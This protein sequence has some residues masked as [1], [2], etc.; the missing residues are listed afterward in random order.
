MDSK[1]NR[2]SRGSITVFLCLVVTLLMAL[3]LSCLESARA[4]AARFMAESYVDVAATSAL[5]DFDSV[6]FERYHVFG[7]HSDVDYSMRINMLRNMDNAIGIDSNLV[8]MGASALEAMGISDEANSVLGNLEMV[9]LTDLDIIE[10]HDYFGMEL[11]DLKI[12]NSVP[13][14]GR[15]GDVF[16]SQAVSYAEKSIP[17]TLIEKVLE[18]AG[19]LSKT[20]VLEN[21]MS[22]KSAAYT[23]LEEVDR[24]ASDL[25]MLIDG[26]EVEK[27]K[28]LFGDSAKAQKNCFKS[29]AFHGAD[30]GALNITSE[31]VYNNLKSYIVDLKAP[32]DVLEKTNETYQKNVIA[33]ENNIKTQN[34]INNSLT[35]IQ[36]YADEY[37]ARGEAVPDSLIQSLSELHAVLQNYVFQE[38][39]LKEE[40]EKLKKDIKKQLKAF[41]SFKYD[42]LIT[43][44]QSA[45]SSLNE[46]EESSKTALTELEN[47]KKTL[48]DSKE[49]LDE[50]TYKSLVS[51]YEE[52]KS[53]L[54]STGS[55]VIKNP[56]LLKNSINQDISV[57]QRIVTLA[58]SVPASAEG[59]VSSW[60]YSMKHEYAAITYAGMDFN[61]G[62]IT[63]NLTAVSEDGIKKLLKDFLSAGISSLVFEDLSSLSTSTFLDILELPTVTYTP[64]TA[65]K[66]AL[67]SVGLDDLLNIIQNG[68]YDDM[69]GTLTDSVEQLTNKLFFILY[70]SE[71]FGS[72][73][74]QIRDRKTV[75]ALNGSGT[76]KSNTAKTDKDIQYGLEYILYG[77]YS[78]IQN[79]QRMATSLIMLRTGLNFVSIITDKTARTEALAGAAALVG[80][81]GLPF[82]IKGVA[83]VIELAWAFQCA[84]V[85]VATIL[86]G[87]SI[88]VFINIVDRKVKFAEVPTMSKE[89]IISKAKA[90]AS[91]EN[92]AGMSYNEYLYIF[93]LFKDRKVE[94]FRAMDLIQDDIRK[95]CDAG[96]KIEDRLYSF[97]VDATF[98]M[99][100]RYMNIPQISGTLM[101][102]I[103]F[104]NYN[105]KGGYT[106]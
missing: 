83:I 64:D 85:E 78:D 77:S 1:Y 99:Q 69:L 9:D 53:I 51:E 5:G 12:D 58:K 11:N 76:K 92:P 21:V 61:Y 40:Q 23:S 98:S 88:P 50:E 27:K 100:G 52:D 8:N 48:D 36:N 4:Q 59:D 56:T 43:T 75:S 89:K 91:V 31:P 74:D 97:D 35:M 90:C 30:Q 6:L 32:L 15:N 25:L 68:G 87:G 80:I 18:H 38:K 79:V 20:S 46:L 57:L 55:A 81:T 102:E 34:N 17:G 22:N 45:L 96:Y 39:L 14:T 106:Y 66:S 95:N 94:C 44:L 63:K 37:T 7:T 19:I 71:A 33:L 86:L 3:I 101:S 24:K 2:V 62:K 72:Y 73:T 28:T 47:Y 29:R 82:L 65:D 93:L 26:L 105:V 49:D 13:L 16:Y 104:F 67:P 54:S 84:L 41:K 42:G 103:P 60:I 70:M 10:G